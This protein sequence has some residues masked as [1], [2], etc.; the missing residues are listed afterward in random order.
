MTIRYKCAECGAALN[1]NDELAGTEGNCPRCQVQFTVPAPDS[2]AAPREVVSQPAGEVRKRAGGQSDG[3]LLSE[4]DI[5][6]FLSGG[7]DPTSERRTSAADS[8]DEIQTAQVNPFDEDADDEA[9]KRSRK[10]KTKRTG[11]AAA[12]PDS[13]E[14]AS[15]ARNL[16][17]KGGQPVER[18]EPEKRKRRPFGG[19]DE[20]HEGQISSFK[21]A[22]TYIAKLGWPYVTGIGVFLGFCIWLSFSMM[23]HFEGPPLAPV[24]G[25][26]TLDGKPLNLAIVKFVPLVQG[27]SGKRAGA[28][29][30]GFTDAAGKY[31]LT[32]AT[33][34]GKPI[35]G[36]IIG[37]HQVQIQL[38]DP[39]GTQ[40]VPLRY[41]TYQSE[42]KADVKKGI[43][44]QD[45]DLKS[46]PTEKTE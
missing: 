19:R 17:G 34:D 1:I 32:Y 43:G 3:G 33:D 7:P 31:S 8:D 9:E 11:T 20:R 4:D 29:S 5:G 28:T 40:L 26:V 24:S 35:M 23:K 38:N 41:S 36:A 13:A 25:T 2:A 39:S 16:M 18:D 44:P 27:D 6:D 45:F 15:I 30:F 37:P 12:K 42:L 21:E 22:V 46:E 14:S 10:Q